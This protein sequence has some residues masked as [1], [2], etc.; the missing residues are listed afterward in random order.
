MSEIRL[1]EYLGHIVTAA[2]ACSFVKDMHQQEFEEDRR[3]QQAVVMS[4]MIIGEAATRIGDR[5]P[6][7]VQRHSELPWRSMRGMRNRIVHGY[8]GINLEVVCGILSNNHC[9]SCWINFQCLPVSHNNN[10]IS[11]REI[12]ETQGRID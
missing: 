4:L 12:V 7:F 11:V 5:Y 8:F 2:D 9:H 6:E 10:D 3:T 1:E